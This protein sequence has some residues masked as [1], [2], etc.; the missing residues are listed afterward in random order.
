MTVFDKEQHEPKIDV[1]KCSNLRIKAQQLGVQLPSKVW[2]VP[3]SFETLT[4]L[5]NIRYEPDYDLTQKILKQN[6]IEYSLLEEG[7]TH[8]SKVS[9]HSFEFAIIPLIVFG[10]ELLIKNPEIV[11]LSLRSLF[12]FFKSKSHRDVEKE[13]YVIKS[14]VIKEVKKSSFKRYSYEGSIEGYK[15]FIRFCRVG[16]S[17]HTEFSL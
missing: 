5:E 9:Q 12:N 1:K 14:E 2:I 15:D 17:C 11:D 6:N 10:W 8:Y 3:N 13:N 4:S 7:N 16:G